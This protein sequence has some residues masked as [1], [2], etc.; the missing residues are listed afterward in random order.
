MRVALLVAVTL[1]A[2]PAGA[3]ETGTVH[4]A[5]IGD[6]SNVPERYR[7]AE[8]TFDY[9]MTLKR[10][11]PATGIEVYHVTFPSPVTTPTPENNTVHAEYYRPRG[12]GK[13]PAVIVLDITGGDQSLSR[14][15]A[16]YLAQNRVAGLFVQMAYYGPRR[17]PGSRLR[18]LSPNIPHTL[19][20][21]RQTVLDC[22]CA[23]AWLAARPEVDA[24]RVGILGTSLG[25]FIATLTGEMDPRISRVA[26]LLGGGGLVDAYY[27]HPL[28]RPARTVYELL[29]GT[30]EQVK[31]LLAPADPLT[32]AANLKG[33]PVLMIAAKRDEIVPPCAAVALWEAMGRPK[34]VWYDTTHYGAALYILSALKPVLEH[35]SAE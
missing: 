14:F 5:P 17:P 33:R 31:E 3:G 32:C 28:A 11:L 12:A 8:R 18:L 30:K 2:C 27:D 6:Q 34:I 23:A 4:F 7:L 13:F 19:A 26:I 22:R 9:T 15:I 35:F 24:K 10:D 21:V 16:T 25:S 29:G 20:A 1:T